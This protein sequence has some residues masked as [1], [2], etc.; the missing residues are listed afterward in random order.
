[1]PEKC[2][3]LFVL[4][5][6]FR[7]LSLTLTRASFFSCLLAALQPLF[8]HNHNSSV[9]REPL[10][11]EHR[12]FHHSTFFALITD[13]A[14]R[15]LSSKSWGKRTKKV[16]PFLALSTHSTHN[17][18]A[19]KFR[20]LTLW[21][22]MGKSNDE[23]IFTTFYCLYT[24]CLVTKSGKEFFCFSELVNSSNCYLIQSWLLLS[25]CEPNHYS[26][27][28]FMQVAS[29]KNVAIVFLIYCQSSFFLLL[30]VQ[31]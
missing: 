3:L 5:S 28:N 14:P 19:V 13:N 16:L 2:A 30:F 6:I 31:L 7:C 18:L 17:F 4:W 1:M 24:S 22:L 26:V 27:Y 12:D 15:E 11:S 8:D 23:R 25:N 29:K 10:S 20:V 9:V 21:C